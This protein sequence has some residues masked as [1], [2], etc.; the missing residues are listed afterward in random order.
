MIT[1]QTV[2]H[3]AKTMI[4]NDFR[5]QPNFI[6]LEEQPVSVRSEFIAQSGE[7]TRKP[8]APVFIFMPHFEHNSYEIYVPEGKNK[9]S[10]FL[11]NFDLYSKNYRIYITLHCISGE[12]SNEA[13]SFMRFNISGEQRKSSVSHD[14]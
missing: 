8:K 13:S 14:L 12:T 6:A 1:Q 7:A 11:K 3:Q 10:Q 5:V 9:V 2:E 4:E